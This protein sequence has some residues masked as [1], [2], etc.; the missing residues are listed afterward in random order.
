MS[1]K[2]LIR[3]FKL[4]NNYPMSVD[5]YSD[6]VVAQYPNPPLFE[7]NLSVNGETN[8]EKVDVIG[9]LV[10]WDTPAYF[11]ADYFDE[12]GATDLTTLIGSPYAPDGTN[13][14]DGETILFTALTTPA[15]NGVYMATVVAGDV[16]AWTRVNFGQ[17]RETGI[18]KLNDSVNIL[19]GT[20]NTGNTFYCDDEALVT[21]DIATGT[22]DGELEVQVKSGNSGWSKLD[23]TPANPTITSASGNLNINITDFAYEKMRVYYKANSGVGTLNVTLT[24]KV[25]GA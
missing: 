6:E 8:V 12:A 21:F 4:I 25:V 7:T 3:P 20:V 16:T 15:D 2:S 17:D 13:V 11:S 9:L 22:P 1:R 10:E 23:L 14:A 18:P 5:V 19:A 24:A